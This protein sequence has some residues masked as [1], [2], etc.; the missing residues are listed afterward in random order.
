MRACFGIKKRA[1]GSL[2]E[3]EADGDEEWRGVCDG[4]HDFYEA[5]AIRVRQLV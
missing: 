5:V 2:E 4:W 3:L 1:G